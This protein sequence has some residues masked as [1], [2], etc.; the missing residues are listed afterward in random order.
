[1]KRTAVIDSSCLINLTHLDLAPKLVLYFDRIWVPR[2]VQEEVNRKSRFRYRLRKLYQTGPYEKCACVD[3][4]NVQLL[5][6]ELGGGEAEGLAQAQEK[7]AGFFIADEARARKFAERRGL[8]SIGTVRL[9]AR[10]SRE[11]Y[12]EDTH[13]LVQ[14]LRREL[15]FRVTDAIVDQAIADSETFHV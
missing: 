9:L 14:K 7:G 2:R 12:A 4:Y 1:M 5:E 10:L 13:V 8:T 11:R 6:R 3:R 15:R